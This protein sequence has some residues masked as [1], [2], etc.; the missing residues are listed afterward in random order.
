[1]KFKVEIQSF[2]PCSEAKRKKERK[3]SEKSI[4]FRIA[5]A[6]QRKKKKNIGKKNIQVKKKNKENIVR[7]FSIFPVNK[8]KR[9]RI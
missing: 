8:K 2:F 7:R 4:H 5:R 6:T 9:T 3:R 1:M